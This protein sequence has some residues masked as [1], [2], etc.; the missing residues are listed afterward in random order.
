MGKYAEFNFKN[1]P[2]L[3]QGYKKYNSLY[4][5][6]YKLSEKDAPGTDKAIELLEEYAY[7]EFALMIYEAFAPVKPMLHNR[8]QGGD[9][10]WDE[11]FDKPF[12]E[13]ETTQKKYLV[14]LIRANFVY[15]LPD[16]YYGG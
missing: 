6:M 15:V 4:N 16:E 11:V 14:G 13:L 7:G 3:K 5:K 8:R 9:F 1:Y 2:K 10:K 12:A